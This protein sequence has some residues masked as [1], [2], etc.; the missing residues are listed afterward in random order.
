MLY[1]YEEV[2]IWLF[3]PNEYENQVNIV[4][5]YMLCHHRSYTYIF[6]FMNLQATKWVCLYLPHISVFCFKT[7]FISLI[8]NLLKKQHLIL[9]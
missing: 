7:F 9:K 5:N 3:L 8:F 2:V 4:G 6:M 1:T